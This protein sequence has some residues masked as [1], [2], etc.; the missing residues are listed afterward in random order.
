MSALN[1][2]IAD[3]ASEGATAANEMRRG[4]WSTV[5]DR[6]RRDPTTMKIKCSKIFQQ[7]EVIT[8]NFRQ[9]APLTKIK[10]MLAGPFF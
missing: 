3:T 4:Y 6:L 5:W 9:W 10:H 1:Q 2:T 7:K 8:F